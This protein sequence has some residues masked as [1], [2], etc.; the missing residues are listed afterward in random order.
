M[1]HQCA[2]CRVPCETGGY[3][4]VCGVRASTV[5]IDARINAINVSDEW[6]K[7]KKAKCDEEDEADD[8][9]KLYPFI[10]WQTKS[11]NR[12]AR[13]S[14]MVAARFCCRFSRA[15][16]YLSVSQVKVIRVQ[17]DNIFFSRFVFVPHFAFRLFGNVAY[18]DNDVFLRKFICLHFHFQSQSRI[19]SF[20]LRFSS[21]LFFS[22]LYDALKLTHFG[23][24]SCVQH[25]RLKQFFLVLSCRALFHR[26]FAMRILSLRCRLSS[27]STKLSNIRTESN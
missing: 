20:S 24:L 10:R 23:I 6:K 5:N 7:W 26:L 9:E 8:G 18:D 1:E 25:N 12:P 4:C 27:S 17:S 21:L 2:V 13:L 14:R 19:L 16:W 22:S 15:L 3:V 11:V